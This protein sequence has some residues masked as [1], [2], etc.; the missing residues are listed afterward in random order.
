MLA[1]LILTAFL[2]SRLLANEDAMTSTYS[3][4]TSTETSTIREN[5]K[6]AVNDFKEKRMEN[7]EELKEK[8]Q[9]LK[10]ERKQKIVE[11]MANRFSTVKSKWVE[12]WNSVLERLTKILDKIE[13]EKGN[14][15]SISS[16]RS[17]ISEAQTLIDDLSEKD[18]SVDFASEDTLK[19]DIKSL[20]SQFKEDHLKVLT[21]IREAKKSVQEVFSQTRSEKGE[22]TS[23]E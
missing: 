1:G 12:H 4:E 10:D 15:D 21:S 11:N 7:R 13:S 9:A 20:I 22:N 14:S 5:R 2:T 18:Y 23:E 8:I 3:N 19:E 16:A 17:K 6:E